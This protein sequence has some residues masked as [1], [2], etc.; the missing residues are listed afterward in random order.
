MQTKTMRL[1]RTSYQ[2]EHLSTSIKTLG[3]D[4]LEYHVRM[5]HMTRP[6]K[7]RQDERT[8]TC[9][10][11]QNNSHHVNRGFGCQR[12]SSVMA[13]DMYHQTAQCKYSEDHPDQPLG[14]ARPSKDQ[15]DVVFITNLHNANLAKFITA[16][17]SQRRSKIEIKNSG[18]HRHKKKKKTSGELPLF[19]SPSVN[20]SLSQI[21]ISIWTSRN[22]QCKNRAYK[23]NAC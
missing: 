16:T 13:V 18:W 4:A 11:T 15:G 19:Q 14:R 10:N 6:H 1:F 22:T 17:C 21:P 20:E 7:Q 9:T 8:L 3:R 12:P 2:Q 23:T 5:V